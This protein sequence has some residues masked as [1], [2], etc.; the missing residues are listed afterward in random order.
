[1]FITLLR[2]AQQ[3]LVDQGLLIVEGSASH[4]DTPQTVGLLWTSDQ[5]DTVNSSCQHSTIKRDKL[6]CHRWGSNI[7]SQ[8]ASGSIPTP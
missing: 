6:P 4:P 5:P 7:Q 2:M 3:P 1:M 8:Q